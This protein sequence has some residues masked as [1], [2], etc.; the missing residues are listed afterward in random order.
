[1]KA[2]LL[3]AGYATRLHPL[4]KNKPKPLLEVAGKPIVEHIIDKIIEIT[5]IDRIYIVTNQKFTSNFEEWSKNHKSKISIEIINDKTTSNED[6]LGAV[7]DVNFV[8]ETKQPNED[9][10]VVAGD[11]LFELSLVDLNNFFK[12][13]NKTII[14]LYDVKDKELAKKY[15]IVAIN[16]NNKVTEFHEKPAEPKSTLASTGIYIFQKKTIN[17]IKNYINEGNSPDKTGEFLEWLFK[18]EEVYGFVSK[19]HW[20][21][22]GS[23]EQLEEAR[24]EFKK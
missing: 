2:I 15:G 16:E 22:I 7:G 21:D 18:K 11:N 13:K 3:A 12:E 10:L 20:Y 23:F 5:D 9:I 17:L 4:T 6:R 1:M 24:K 19:E 14:A 8:I